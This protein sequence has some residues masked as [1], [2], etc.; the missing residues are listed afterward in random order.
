MAHY[1]VLLVR[2]IKTL[3]AFRRA[4]NYI[5]RDNA[6]Q[7]GDPARRGQNLTI[8]GRDRD[9][10]AYLQERLSTL[11]RAP[12]SN[13]VL[14][15]E[16]I[17]SASPSW[18]AQSSPAEI[19]Q[20]IDRT[21][22]FM[23]DQ[24]GADNIVLMELHADQTSYNLHTL[25]VPIDPDTERLNARRWTGGRT[26]LRAMHDRLETY[27]RDMGLR[28]GL[29]GSVMTHDEVRQW[30]K[31]VGAP[32]PYVGDLLRGIEV[33]P[34]PTGADPRAW[35]VAQT[36]KV[37]SVV[38]DQLRDLTAK[39]TH[40]EM[41]NDRLRGNVDMLRDRVDELEALVSG[42]G[43]LG[44]QEEPSGKTRLGKAK[45]RASR[46]PEPEVPEPNEDAMEMMMGMMG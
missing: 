2:K 42:D 14:T 45:G 41:D 16:Y 19:G 22:Q 12:R 10:T 1:N 13:S 24:H 21:R 17:D 8:V 46:T 23:A 3:S 11:S 43:E 4:A 15:L 9:P 36:D 40:L 20:W 5:E 39:T 34:L 28:R 29:E 31:R 7:H 38:G 33:E 30:V 25:V 32:T 18:F 6:P 26:K 44:S 37:R 27:T 35:A